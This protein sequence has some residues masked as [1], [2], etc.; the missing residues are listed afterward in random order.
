[1]VLRY[2]FQILN[3]GFPFLY[4]VTDMLL[5]PFFDTFSYVDLA[6]LYQGN[7]VIEASV[8]ST[9]IFY[10]FIFYMFDY[11]SDLEYRLFFRSHKK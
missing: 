1:M 7:S 5:V 2:F 6:F 8:F 10:A 11:I 3:L 4:R 9:I